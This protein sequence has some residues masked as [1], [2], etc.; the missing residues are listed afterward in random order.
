MSFL[1]Q[2]LSTWW[3]YQR[4]LR[5]MAELLQV[6]LKSLALWLQFG[7]GI[8]RVIFLKHIGWGNIVREAT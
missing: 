7:G 4:L 5:A 1:S 6:Q 8:R 2:I 3:P